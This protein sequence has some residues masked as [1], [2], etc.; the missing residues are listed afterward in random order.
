MATQDQ[1]FRSQTYIQTPEPIS[2]PTPMFPVRPPVLTQQ[3]A[4]DFQ[5]LQESWNKL[6]SQMSER[7]E[8]SKLLK[9]TVKNTYKKL[10]SIPK[11]PLEKASNTALQKPPRK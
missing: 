5:L 4:G 3:I 1:T 9:R 7:V 10:T 8:A 2:Y 6:S 11:P